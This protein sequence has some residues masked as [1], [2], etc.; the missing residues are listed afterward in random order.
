MSNGVSPSEFTR[1]GWAPLFNKYLQI[2]HTTL[3]YNPT[4]ILISAHH[5]LYNDYDNFNA[6][7][8]TNMN[9]CFI[10]KHSCI[11]LSIIVNIIVIC[12]RV[13]VH[14]H[15]CGSLLLY[16]IDYETFCLEISMKRYDKF[17]NGPILKVTKLSSMLH[18]VS[19]PDGNQ[20]VA[21]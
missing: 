10:K 18:N 14:T 7:T 15:V 11:L 13:C 9:F 21:N 8:F 5:L 4:C 6:K 3:L 19:K 20:P 12:V 1:A 17:S 2:T 16:V